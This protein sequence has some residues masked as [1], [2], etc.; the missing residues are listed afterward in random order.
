MLV[1]G[2]RKRYKFISLMQAWHRDI[3]TF[4]FPLTGKEADVSGALRAGNSHPSHSGSPMKESK[5][6]EEGK[7][8]RRGE[9]KAETTGFNGTGSE[10]KRERK[11]H[12]GRGE[13]KPSDNM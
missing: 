3:K 8:E 12:T 7:K 2:D 6:K 1:S 9:S 4:F 5:R 11:K 13:A 10:R